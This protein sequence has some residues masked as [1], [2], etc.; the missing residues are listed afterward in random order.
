MIIDAITERAMPRGVE[1][2]YSEVD[3]EFVD[4]SEFSGGK[5]AVEMKYYLAGRPGAVDRAFLRRSVA[6]RLMV[7][8]G[9]LPQG[10]CLKVY[11]A[12]R[13]FEVQKS[14]F[15]QYLD[16][17]KQLPENKGMDEE[18]LCNIAKKYVSFP[19][20]SRKYSYVHSSGGAV[21]LTIIDEQGRELDMGS[22]FDDF[23]DIASLCAL[24][25]SDNVTAR[26]N[27][28]LLYH[29]MTSAG[30][31]AYP[32]EWWHFDFGDIFYAT[33]TGNAVQ[34]PSVYSYDI[35]NGAV[36]QERKSTMSKCDIFIS[37]CRDGGEAV[38]RLV[39]EMLKNKYNVFFD[40]KSLSTGR[41]DHS[42]IQNVRECNDFVVLLT[43]DCF[44]PRKDEVDWYIREIE[45]AM[46]HG[47]R[48]IPL[49]LEGYTV[50]DSIELA[51]CSEWVSQLVMHQGYWVKVSQIDNAVDWIVEHL[52]ENTKEKPSVYETLEGWTEFA[53]RLSNPATVDKLPEELKMSIIER[54]LN[55]FLD[56]YSAPIIKSTLERLSGKKY[57]VRTDFRYDVDINESFNFRLV[58]IDRDKYYEIS[59]NLTYTKIFRDN[60][61]P[62]QFWISFATGLTELDDELHAENFFFSENLT[63]DSGDMKLLSALSEEDKSEF[64]NSVMRVK[65][66]INGNVLTPDKIVIDESG[67]FAK[68]TAPEV[69]TNSITVRIRFKLPQGYERSFFFACISEPTYSP[70]VRVSYDDTAFDVEM[71]PFLTRSLTAKDTKVFE[72]V[73]ELSVEK[74]WIMPVSGAI[75]LIIKK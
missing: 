51:C 70:Y 67:I 73:R 27:R 8:L 22:G 34:Y 47:K 42:L 43:K 28:R 39:Y 74:E 64:Y 57:N 38:G 71:I 62:E 13:P 50:P 53:N 3:E 19:D 61:P 21:D 6:E 65:L 33:L 40:H 45:T 49:M 30:F 69:N 7:A 35:I 12:W 66:S 31:T 55:S 32:H 16:E 18:T 15:D 37:Y 48:I 56:D 58:D 41:Y 72:G 29:V 11:D 4:V 54:S 1:L 5:I 46:E 25:G 9:L 14:L 24:E 20:K 36:P 60:T 52:S 68:Y 63:I 2:R 23:S 26:N 10:Y 17:L 44:K 75:F 59:E